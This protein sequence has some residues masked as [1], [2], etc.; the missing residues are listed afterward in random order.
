MRAVSSQRLNFRPDLPLD[1]DQVEP[2]GLVE[3]PRGVTAGLDAG[4]H[5]VEAAGLGG[6]QQGREQLLADPQAVP[7]PTD[8][9]RVLHRRPVGRPLLVGRDRS[10]AD[11]LPVPLGHQH[12]EGPGPAGQPAA[13]IVAGPRDEVER[14][15]RV[16]A[17][18]S[19]RWPGWPRRRP[20]RPV[21]SA[22]RR[23]SGRRAGRVDALTRSAAG[24][25]ERGST[26]IG[27]AGYRRRGPGSGGARS[28]LAW[29]A[30]AQDRYAGPSV[31]GSAAP[32]LLAQSAEHSHGKAG[33]VGSI[34]TEG[35][36]NPAGPHQGGVA[37]LV[38][39]SGS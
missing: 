7:I 39:A 2:T 29:S 31:R 9:D 5:R 3:R 26:A 33:V 23:W 10:E 18:R 30:R 27:A 15:R 6:V 14:R 25:P 8:V 34:P 28:A 11:H 1:A 37:Q 35:S 13:L 12:A 19:C 21:G 20:R 22:A 4:H 36:T 17:P 32:A 24:G 16:L 38:R